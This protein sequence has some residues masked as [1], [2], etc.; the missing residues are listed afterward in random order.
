M[1]ATK[2][3]TLKNKPKKIGPFRFAIWIL[4]CFCY[5]AYFMKSDGNVTSDK[6]RN[7]KMKP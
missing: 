1:D 6:C 5:Y 4:H 2:E 3:H 7:V